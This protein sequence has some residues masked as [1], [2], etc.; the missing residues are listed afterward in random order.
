[1]TLKPKGTAKGKPSQTKKL[2]KGRDV[3]GPVRDLRIA[4]R[5]AV[6]RGFDFLCLAISE[7][8]AFQESGFDYL[9]SLVTTLKSRDVV[10]RK[11]SREVGQNLS[12]RWIAEN[13]TVPSDADA[14]TITQLVFGSLSSDEF[15]VVHSLK[16]AIQAA[17]SNFSAEHYFWFDPTTE[18]PPTDVPEDCECGVA[19]YRGE[20]KCGSCGESL[21]TR[22]RYEVW[23]VALIRSYLGERY[24]VKLGAKYSD[25][26]KWLP[27]MRPYPTV[28]DA[29]AADFGW[30][31]YAITHIVYTLNDYNSYQL[32]RRWLP[33]EYQALSS[34][35]DAFISMD[36]PETVGEILDCLKSFKVNNSNP[37]IQRG[38]RYLLDCQNPDG[39]WG[40]IDGDADIYVR[41]HTTITALY[42][43]DNYFRRGT[44]FSFPEI[45][46][47]LVHRD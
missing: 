3:P 8:T 5:D 32:N 35:L 13:P 15:G 30:S 45:A 22:S 38:A 26:L 21:D 36:D 11:R 16:P 9:F 24:G 42:G 2:K 37:L 19:N 10:I 41:H 27:H 7:K 31:I 44:G 34:S 6:R 23:L 20:T 28:D 29:S 39:S 18:S 46:Q 12:R 25:V 43:L 17:A 47:F 40:E 4:S 14:D 33:D 1:M